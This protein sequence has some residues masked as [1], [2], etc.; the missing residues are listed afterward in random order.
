MTLAKT[1]TKMWPTENEV[2]INLILTD[3]ERP[4]L[5][6]GAQVVVSKTFKGNIPANADMTDE[7]QLQ[8][9]KK[10]QAEIDNYKKLKAKYDKAAY[11]TKVNQIDNNLTL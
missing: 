7:V 4:D 9:V 10:A 6:E 5:G 3:S 1:V 2:G 11:Q 8:I